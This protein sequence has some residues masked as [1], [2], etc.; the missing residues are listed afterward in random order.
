MCHNSDVGRG[1]VRSIE[2]HRWWPYPA[3]RGS[4]HSAEAIL[5]RNSELS[6]A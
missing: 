3:M 2:G 6:R 1:A 4:F 5:D